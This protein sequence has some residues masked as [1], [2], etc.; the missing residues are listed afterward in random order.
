MTRKQDR[1]RRSAL[2]RWRLGAVAAIA[3]VALVAGPAALA[4]AE[5]TLPVEDETLVT[6]VVDETI[7]EDV[8]EVVDETIVEDVEEVVEEV[9]EEEGEAAKAYPSPTPTQKPRVPVKVK[10]PTPTFT[11]PCGPGNASWSGP[12]AEGVVWT[13]KQVGK[14]LVIVATPAKGYYFKLGTQAIWKAKDSKEPCVTPV[15]ALF[16]AEPAPP[17]CDTAGALPDLSEVFPNVELS[18][19]RAYDGPGDYVLTATALNGYEF[20]GGGTVR[21]RTVTVLAAIGYQ[22]EDAE[23]PCFQANETLVTPTADY[24]PPSCN[25]PGSITLGTDPGYE[26]TAVANED[27]TYTYTAVP[28]EGYAFPDGAQTQW[29]ADLGPALPAEECPTTPVEP[30]P[31][32]P[33]ETGGLASTGGGD[34]NP[35]VPLGG[36][37]TMMLGIV[38]VA[39]ASYRRYLLN[40]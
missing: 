27:G 40:H 4:S 31:G 24:S 16:A 18:F 32:D 19:D 3:A 22:S 26:W 12:D 36:G 8:D 15:P 25:A 1:R 17:T 23:A 30:E 5:D 38:L 11:D 10:V 35:L 39:M 37:L 13:T 34:V 14:W 7:V 20:E 21:E 2:R 33:D 29:V 9:V 28:N 6:E